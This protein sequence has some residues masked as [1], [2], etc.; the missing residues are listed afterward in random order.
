M[1]EEEKMWSLGFFSVGGSFWELSSHQCYAAWARE[2][3]IIPQ[4]KI[5][6]I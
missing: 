2:Q 6:Y 1:E 4:K 3:N 5:G